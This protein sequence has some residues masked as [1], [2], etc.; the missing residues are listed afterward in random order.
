LLKQVRRLGGAY[1]G[2][3][4]P[5]SQLAVASALAAKNLRRPVRTALDLKTNMELVGK[6]SPYLIKYNVKHNP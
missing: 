1:G 5:P 4:T 2:K 3:I 6:R